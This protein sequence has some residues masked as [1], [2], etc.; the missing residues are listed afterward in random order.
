MGSGITLPFSPAPNLVLTTAG[1]PSAGAIPEDFAA[2]FA[3]DAVANELMIA[4]AGSVLVVGLT[5]STGLVTAP[6]I[7]HHSIALTALAAGV[8]TTLA[9]HDQASTDP[10]GPLPYLAIGVVTA[11]SAPSTGAAVEAS[12]TSNAAIFVG[13]AAGTSLGALAGGVDSATIVCAAAAK[14][15]GGD[16]I[17][18][19]VEASAAC[20]VLAATPTYAFAGASAL[21]VLGPLPGLILD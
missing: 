2:M 21:W 14:L 15:A 18:L 4:S 19:E 9:T 17:T 3:W 12:L 1:A 11:G 6:S 20:D 5:S 10:G 8:L 16:T 7:T 13:G